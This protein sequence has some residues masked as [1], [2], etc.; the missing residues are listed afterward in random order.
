MKTVVSIPDRTF[1]AAEKL[2]ERWGISRGELYARA[3]DAF[4]QGHYDDLVTSRL[5][6]IYG[7]GRERSFLDPALATMLQ[8]TLKRKN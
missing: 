8:R 6:E 2:A 7:P 3:L 1:R 4:L 5:N